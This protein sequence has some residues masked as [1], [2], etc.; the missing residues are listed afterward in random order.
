MPRGQPKPLLRS[1]AGAPY[2]GG[3]VDTPFREALAGS[4][5]STAMRK[6]N[7]IQVALLCAAITAVAATL[8][9]GC[10]GSSDDTTEPTGEAARPA[11]SDFLAVDGRSLEQLVSDEGKPSDLVAA[12]SG[13]V[14]RQGENRYGFGIFNVDA[15][16]VDD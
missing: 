3:G 2:R 15:S 4:L 16:P 12:P 7:G 14:Y 11:A 13:Q 6:G 10:G 8:I 5:A 1:V 9:A